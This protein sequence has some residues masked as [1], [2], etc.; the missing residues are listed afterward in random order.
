MNKDPATFTCRNVVH[1]FIVYAL[2]SWSRDLNTKFTLGG[3]LFGAV[4]LIKNDDPD[5]YGCI[6]YGIVFDACW[7]FSI[8][9]EFGKNI[10]ILILRLLLLRGQ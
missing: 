6:S 5:K 8:N 4:K 2:D 7:N 1:F 9:A 10:I 3:C